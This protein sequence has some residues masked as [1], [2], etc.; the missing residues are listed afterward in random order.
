MKIILINGTAGSGKSTV[1]EYLA[2]H[3]RKA[4]NSVLVHGNAEAVKDVCRNVYGWDGKNKDERCRRLF[5]N[6]TNAGYNFDPY[7]WERKTRDYIEAYNT[8]V[9]E[10]DVVIIQDWRYKSTYDYFKNL[11]YKVSTILVERPNYDNGYS[12]Q[13]KKDPSESRILE[14]ADYDILIINSGELD[15][16]KSR[17]EQTFRHFL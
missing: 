12:E 17:C 11:G 15:H 8:T 4:G 6:V 16:L 1:T 10:L 2:N 9:Q 14:F 5:I 3:F 7:F 13:V